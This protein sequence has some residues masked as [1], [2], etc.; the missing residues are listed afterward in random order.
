MW[1]NWDGDMLDAQRN[2][3][4]EMPGFK[5][6]FWISKRDMLNIQQNQRIGKSE[7]SQMFWEKEILGQSLRMWI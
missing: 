4:A 3:A 2:S 5:T 1:S 7:I 6:P